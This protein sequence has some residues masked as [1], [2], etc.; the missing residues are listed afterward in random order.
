MNAQGW[1]SG[2]RACYMGSAGLGDKILVGTGGGLHSAVCSLG[3][4]CVLP[5][6]QV[7]DGIA[8]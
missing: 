2:R 3:Q 6:C 5:T 8:L 7:I 1:V 4:H